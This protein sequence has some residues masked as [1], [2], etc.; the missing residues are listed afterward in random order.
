MV[1]YFSTNGVQLHT[2]N[3]A[4]DTHQTYWYDLCAFIRI[5]RWKRISWQKQTEQYSHLEQSRIFAKFASFALLVSSVCFRLL[6]ILSHILQWNQLVI[7]VNCV[8]LSST[9]PKPLSG[10]SYLRKH[11]YRNEN[12][13][14]TCENA[15][16]IR[17]YVWIRVDN[18]AFACIRQLRTSLMPDW[19]CPKSFHHHQ[20][21]CCLQNRRS[22]S[23]CNT[24]TMPPRLEDFGNSQKNVW[25]L[26]LG[27][28]FPNF[29]NVISPEHEFAPRQSIGVLED[30]N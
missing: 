16:A 9:G 24:C 2:N 27:S 8:K 5:L 17:K 30:T 13:T 1:R 10:A 19:H 15:T 22:M 20:T 28:K 18:A 29:Q 6:R 11:T 7:G 23:C 14:N 4:S 3:H 26:N 21:L 25:V 12:Y